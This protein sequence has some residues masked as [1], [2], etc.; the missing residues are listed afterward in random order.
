MG[1]QYEEYYGTLAIDR[2]TAVVGYSWKEVH[3]R[4]P[5]PVESSERLAKGTCHKAADPAL[6][7]RPG[8]K[9]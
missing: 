6:Q 7:A 8:P 1:C 9:L 3:F 5:K 2:Q 4:Y